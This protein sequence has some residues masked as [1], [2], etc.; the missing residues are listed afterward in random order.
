[1][2]FAARTIMPSGKVLNSDFNDSVIL[3][4][5]GASQATASI[6]FQTN[7]T[8]VGA[9]DPQPNW[10][11]PTT[12]G[13]GSSYWV[14]VNAPTV[15]AFT[16]G[17]TG[18]RLALSSTRLYSVTTSGGGVVRTAEAQATYQIWN[19]A[20][21]GSQVGSGTITLFAQVDNS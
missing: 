3:T 15:G 4:G 11:D 16:V 12:V 1:M 13:I 9:N 17:T 6:E 19:A 10:F 7:G 20:S 5:V 8:V 14:L 18:S 21:G 2:T